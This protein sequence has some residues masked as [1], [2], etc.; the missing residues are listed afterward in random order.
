M[1]LRSSQVEVLREV[2]RYEDGRASDRQEGASPARI[3]GELGRD[4]RSVEASL[5]RLGDELG[6]VRPIG[7][8]PA[9]Y[10]LTNKGRE[11]LQREGGG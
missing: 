7:Y 8:P 3:A 9:V 11:A 2:E 10:V 4:R 6:Y 5:F 1:S